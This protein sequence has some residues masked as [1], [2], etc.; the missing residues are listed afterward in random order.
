MV[1]LVP[2]PEIYDLVQSINRTQDS[3][4]KEVEEA[5]N[6]LQRSSEL[7]SNLES[8]LTEREKKLKS[9]KE[10]YEKVS[11]L[12]TLTA[13]QANAVVDKLETTL[14][15]NRNFERTLSL[16]LNV[17]AGLIVL[18]IGV[19]FADEISASVTYIRDF[20]FSEPNE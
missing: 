14:G 3:F 4:D 1:P 8:Q 13:E 11:H 18:A 17:L 20:F 19:I 9:L 6:A 5:V 16:T 7:I 10:E 2:M 12:S 15:K